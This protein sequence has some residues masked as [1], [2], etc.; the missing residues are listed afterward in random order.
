MGL[1][2]QQR[3]ENMGGGGPEVRKNNLAGMSRGRESTGQGTPQGRAGKGPCNP[4]LPQKLGL[5][6]AGLSWEPGLR[7][8]DQQKRWDGEQKPKTDWRVLGVNCGVCVAT[9]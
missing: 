5:G 7:A 6:W 8:P 2:S 1:D 3:S 9:C 4:G